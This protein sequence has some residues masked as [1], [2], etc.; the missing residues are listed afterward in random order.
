MPPPPDV[1]TPERELPTDAVIGRDERGAAGPERDLADFT[2]PRSVLRLIPFAILIGAASA[3]VALILLDLIGLITNLLYYHRWSLTLVSPAGNALG[4][5]AVA[6]PVVGG[7]IVG[8]MARYGSEQIRGHGIP[9]AMETILVGGS[10]VK[11]RLTVLKPVSSAISIGTGGPFGAEGPIILTA[12]A[13]GSVLAQF[14]QFSAAERRS[15]LVAGAAGGM[16][17]VFGTPVAAVLLGVELLVFEWKP[18]SMVPIGVAAA[19]AEFVRMQFASAGLLAAEPLFPTSIAQ[20]PGWAPFGG[21]IIIGLAG[22][23]TAWLLTEA[24]YGAEDVFKKLP[25]HWMWW[26][27]IGGL[28]VGLGGLIEPRAL[29][30]GYDTI[31]AQLAGQVALGALVSIFVVKLIIWAIALGSGTSGGILAPILIMGCAVGGILT[32]ILPHATEG[33]WIFLGM[34]AALAG[35]TRSPLTAIV[36]SVELTHDVEVLLPLLVVSTV[37]HLVSV[38]I[39]KRSILTEKVA[40][41]GFHVLREYE[42]GPLEVLFVRDLMATDVLTVEVGS[43][44]RAVHAMLREHSAMRYQRL[45]PV[46]TADGR[47]VGAISWNDVLERAARGELEGTVDDVMHQRLVVAYPDETLRVVADRMAAGKLGV[48]PV[49][50]RNDPAQLRGL[51][52]QFDLLRARGRM[53]EEE[54]HREQVLDLRIFSAVRWRRR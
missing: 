21:A 30:V 53:L 41:R 24:V 3:V 29:G 52:T 11:P 48:L 1:P 35:V 34:A 33:Y 25:V 39:L 4:A 5:S 14:F 7:V 9:E 36:F 31:A 51:I 12:G 10:K 18:R 27:A 32:P 16:A 22:G 47:L 45:L 40:R 44:L 50:D 38:L 17:G 2:T 42:V 49:V 19:V 54:R 28:V 13:L 20:A 37:A 15:L 8:F 23:I 26:P 46:T 43:A 6:I